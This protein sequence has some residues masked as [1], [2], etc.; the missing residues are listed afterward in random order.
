ML[1]L[2]LLAQQQ[3]C[4][5]AFDIGGAQASKIMLGPFCHKYWGALNLLLLQSGPNIGAE[6][7]EYVLSKREHSHTSCL[8]LL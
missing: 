4:S 7:V 1:R 3:G 2:T 8:N 5:H 6:Y